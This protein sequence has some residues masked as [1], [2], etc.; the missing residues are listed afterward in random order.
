MD[1]IDAGPV[2]LV[3][4]AANGIGLATAQVFCRSGYRV[5]FADLNGAQASEAVAKANEGTSENAYAIAADVTDSESVDRMIGATLDRFGQLDVLVNNAGVPVAH[6]SSEITDREWSE[7]IDVNLSGS[8][9]CARAAYAS[10][11][12]SGSAAIVNVSSETAFVGMPGRAAYT[13]AKAGLIGLTRVLA[14]EWAPEP[15]RVNA[16]APG[17]VRTAG[18]ERRMVGERQAD[19]ARLE[20]LVP[21]GRLCRP[22]EVALAIRFL[23]SADASYITGQT[24]V[25][26]GGVSINGY[27]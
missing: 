14:V 17:Y 27:S 18:F 26:D 24:L 11:C 2:A 13:S 25:V 6:R 4:G 10:L 3:T 5:V 1:G 9:R 20:A 22:D 21:L 8:L 23:A 19:L 15:I 12:A 7:A 16:V